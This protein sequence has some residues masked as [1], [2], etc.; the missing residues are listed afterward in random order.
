M[1]IWHV[2]QGAALRPSPIDNEI[3][4][5]PPGREWVELNEEI[6]SEGCLVCV[7]EI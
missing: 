7:E 5:Y 3:G 2:E 1:V 6:H 4:T